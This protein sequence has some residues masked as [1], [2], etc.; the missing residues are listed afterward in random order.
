MPPTPPT[1]PTANELRRLVEGL[2][3]IRGK[4]LFVALKNGRL[5]LETERP[6]S[7]AFLIVRTE[8]SGGD[9]LRGTE[10]LSVTNGNIPREADAAFTTQ[11]AYEKFVL[12]YY[13]RTRT[14]T[15]LQA[16]KDTAYAD[17]VGAIYHEPSSETRTTLGLFVVK[18]NGDIE[19]ID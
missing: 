18:K 8:F 19:P 1:F 4:D 17:D 16:M 15:E 10:A 13:A 11:S 9:G 7:G 2:D 5:V 14:P 6:T 3:G 12:P